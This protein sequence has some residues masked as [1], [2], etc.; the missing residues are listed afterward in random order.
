MSAELEFLEHKKN[1]LAKLN[2]AKSEDLVD[3]D[4]I[5]VIDLINKLDDYYTSSSCYGRVVLLEIPVIGDKKNAVFLGKWHRKV[6]SQ[7][8]LKAAEKASKGLL[9]ILAQSPIIHLGAKTSSAADKM[10]KTAIAS[11]FKLSGLKSFEK[12]I[13]VEVASTERLDAPVGKDGKLFCDEEQ[14]NLLVE[15]ANDIIDKSTSKLSKFEN[16]LRTF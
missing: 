5:P 7:E 2:K 4:I 14:L 11:G 12:S 9:W 6:E 16:S 10:L 3:K 8:I 1:A 13:I 15:I